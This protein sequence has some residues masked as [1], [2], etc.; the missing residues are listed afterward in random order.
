MK[1]PNFSLDI[2]L[3]LCNPENTRVFGSGNLAMFSKT[4][5]KNNRKMILKKIKKQ[6]S[7]LSGGSL[8]NNR[9][10]EKLIEKS[11]IKEKL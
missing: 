4:P 6:R 1:N 9:H 7:I 2:C 8:L 11:F 5:I 3:S 10:F